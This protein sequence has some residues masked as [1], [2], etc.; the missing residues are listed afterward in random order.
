MKTENGGEDVFNMSSQ[1]SQ[2]ADYAASHTLLRPSG[3]PLRA[4]GGFNLTSWA[5][6]RR[7]RVHCSLRVCSLTKQPYQHNKFIAVQELTSWHLWAQ[8]A[9]SCS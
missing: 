8:T 4:A 5:C 6:S 1:H 3:R 7:A 9:Q 2:V